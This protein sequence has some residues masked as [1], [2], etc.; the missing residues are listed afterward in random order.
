MCAFLDDP[1]VSLVPVGAI[2]ADRYSRIAASLR[3]K[4]HPLPT[5]V[6]WIAAHAME[7][8]ADLVSVDRRFRACGRDRVGSAEGRARAELANGVSPSPED[9]AWPSPSSTPS[10]RQRVRELRLS[11]A[12]LSHAPAEAG[13]ACS[14]RGSGRGLLRHPRRSSGLRSD[15]GLDGRPR[16][17]YTPRAFS[18]FR[19]D[20]FLPTA[21]FEPRPRHETPLPT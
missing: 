15:R 12:G 17:Q 16:P 20:S 9:T 3:A 8:R 1:Y 10:S 18:S 13:G 11:D 21:R 5:N 7:T 14:A 2:T 4:D 19:P 6:V